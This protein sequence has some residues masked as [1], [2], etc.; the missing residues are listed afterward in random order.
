M[1][2]VALDFLDLGSAAQT[3]AA[4]HDF[5]DII[6]VGTP[7]IKSVGI[8]SVKH[9]HKQFPDKHIFADLK[10]MDT[11]YLEAELAIT[12]GADFVSVLGVADDMT[13]V[14]AKDACSD[15]GASLVVDMINHPD[16]VSRSRILDKSLDY[17]LIHIGID[18]QGHKTLSHVFNDVLT[19]GVPVAVAGGITDKTVSNY[20]GADIIIVGS[21]ITKS[22]NPVESVT[23]LLG[24]LE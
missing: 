8:Q 4:V 17:V 13:V 16:P 18:Q 10:T 6:E 22:K 3:A 20:K 12:N 15:Y 21:F 24:V 11:G 1:L 2:Q 5:V 23:R 9:L 14:G 7:L 19:L